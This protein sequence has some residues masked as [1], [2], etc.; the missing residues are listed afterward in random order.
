[1]SFVYGVMWGMDLHVTWCSGLLREDSW[2]VRRA[3]ALRTCLYG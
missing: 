1:M 2:H 3:G